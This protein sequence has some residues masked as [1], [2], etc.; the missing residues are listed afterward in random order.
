MD[1]VPLMSGS[2]IRFEF[3]AEP[4]LFFRIRPF[5]IVIHFDVSQRG[6]CFGKCIVYCKR[7]HRGLFCLWHRFV[8]RGEIVKRQPSVGICQPGVSKRVAWIC[9]D[10]LLELRDAKLES[11][12]SSLVPKETAF[13]IVLISFGILRVTLYQT[14]LFVAGELQGKRRRHLCGDRVFYSEYI[15]KTLIEMIRP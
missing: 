14:P 6:M 3:Y 2:V 11:F 10:R 13:Q 15:R 8:G 4:E 7:V 1:G 12:A 5:P 9:F